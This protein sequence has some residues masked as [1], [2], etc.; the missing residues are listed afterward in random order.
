MLGEI[1][2]KSFYH[3]FK[4][5][6]KKKKRFSTDEVQELASQMLQTLAFFETEYIYHTNLTMKN[7]VVDENPEKKLIAKYRLTE[8]NDAL[9]ALLM[10]Y[11]T[12]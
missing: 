1:Y 8:F 11:P 2:K 6:I 12:E 3:D 9:K 5:R 7:I 10:M 4:D